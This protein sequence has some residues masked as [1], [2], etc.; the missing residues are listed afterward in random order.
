M[1]N[2]DS[3]PTTPELIETCTTRKIF[4]LLHGTAK[5]SQFSFMFGPTGRGKTFAA[6]AWLR[7]YGSGAYLRAE[8]RATPAGL[9]RDLSR[10]I[11][12]E[13]GSNAAA[14]RDHIYEHPGFVLLVD[15]CNHLITNTSGVGANALD[16]IRDYYDAIQEE[17][18]RFGVCFIFTDY[19][20]DRLRKC[21]MASFLEQFIHRGDNH[22]N[23]PAKISRPYE[24]VPII[25]TLIPDADEELIDAA[26]GIDN[27]RAIFK[28]IA[29]LKDFAAKYNCRIT[30]KMLRDAQALFESGNY[31]DD[32]GVRHD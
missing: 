29:V 2:P 30:A 22:L 15:E 25:R 26:V 31:P 5:F 16:S 1:T 10:A 20:L 3:I 13:A 8:T 21:R 28:R 7:A 12:G 4:R 32:K 14:I 9:R 19:S 6:K 27:I 18:G 17:G 24:I 23:I 11:F